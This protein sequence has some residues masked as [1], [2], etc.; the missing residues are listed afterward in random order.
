MIRY[1]RGSGLKK[2]FPIRNPKDSLCK[3]LFDKLWEKAES[4][5]QGTL[6]IHYVNHSSISYGK[7]QRVSNKEP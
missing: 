4:F 7:R 6:N 1:K 5:Q 2:E 3:S